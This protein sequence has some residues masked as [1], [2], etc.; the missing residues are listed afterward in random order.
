MYASQ[1]IGLTLVPPILPTTTMTPT[2]TTSVEQ[3]D[4]TSQ[5]SPY[6]ERH[7]VFPLLAFVDTLIGQSKVAYPS[8]EIAA[9]RLALFRP[10]TMVDYAIDTYKSVHGDA[11]AIPA[12][13]QEQKESAGVGKAHGVITELVDGK[14][15]CDMQVHVSL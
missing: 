2:P 11:A 14:G 3:W 8:A 15:Y 9:A 12:E 1:A 6:L 5:I 7:M 13:M 10:T 4:L